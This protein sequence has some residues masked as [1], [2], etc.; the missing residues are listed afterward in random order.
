MLFTHQRKPYHIIFISRRVTLHIV[1]LTP[2]PFN[3][4]D[5]TRTD[6]VEILSFVST[7]NWTTR[8]R[9]YTYPYAMWALHPVY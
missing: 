4:R 2:S 1:G 6:T 7:A 5:R 9:H 3:T 8:A